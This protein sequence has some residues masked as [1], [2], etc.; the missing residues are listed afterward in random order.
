MASPLKPDTYDVCVVGAGPGGATCA[1]YLARRGFRV[2]LLERKQFPRDKICGDA[3]CTRAQVHLKRMGVLQELLAQGQGHW[4]IV[5]GL[6]SPSGITYIGQSRTAADEG[7]VIAV[8]RI[9]LDEKVARAAARAGADLVEN[10]PVAGAEFAAADGL[11]TVRSRTGGQAAYRARALVAAD[12]ASSPL[13][14]SLGLVTGP[15]DAVCSRSYVEASTTAFDAD[16]VL[17]YPRELVP[18]YAVLFREAGGELNYA[19][20]VIPGGRCVPSDLSR[21][22]HHVARHDPGVSRALGPKPNMGTMCGAGLRLG[23]IARSYADHLL[24]VGDAAG[25]IDPLTG[26]GI[27]YAMHAAELAADTLA[28]A[29][30]ADNLGAAF[31]RRYQQRW[32]RA[33]GRDFAWSRRMARLSGRFPI[34]LDGWAAA[35]RRRGGKYLAEWATIMTGNQPKSRFFQ[36]RLALPVLWQVIRHAARRGRP[37]EVT[38]G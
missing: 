3:V 36:P 21:L 22:H 16:G 4:A 5:G 24:V 35:T 11:W 12:G 19:C 37:C 38:A 15:P 32:M 25:H 7:L 13:A 26:E 28:E 2:L 6:V 14:R 29:F 34:L 27:Q 33:F 23:G 8:K 18:G 31:L 10:Y 30:A 20:Y 17:F 9:V 1:Y